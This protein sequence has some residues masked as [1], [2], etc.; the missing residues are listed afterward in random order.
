MNC[1]WYESKIPQNPRR[2]LTCDKPDALSGQWV[3]SWVFVGIIAAI[4]LTFIRLKE[5]R[6]NMVMALCGS[7]HT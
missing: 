6:E 2:W 3:Q 4:L 5:Q 7:A 1:S